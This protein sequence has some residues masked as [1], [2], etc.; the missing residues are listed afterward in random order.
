MTTYE[1]NVGQTIGGNPIEGTAIIAHAPE[2]IADKEMIRVRINSNVK[3]VLM[4]FFKSKEDVI[5]SVAQC[6]VVAAD[7]KNY[8]G[9]EQYVPRIDSSV[10]A[11][12]P[13]FQG[14][15]IITKISH[16]L[17]EDFV[18]SDFSMQYKKI[19]T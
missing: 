4:E 9:Y 16:N 15:L 14:K 5:S 6:N 12:R 3:P 8:R 11:N 7:L 18:I 13:R 1:L 17:A 2:S 10:N 19:K